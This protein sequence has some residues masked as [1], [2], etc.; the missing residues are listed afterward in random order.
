VELEDQSGT[1]SSCIQ[2]RGIFVNYGQGTRMNYLGTEVVNNSNGLPLKSY[3]SKR[4]GNQSLEEAMSGIQ[5]D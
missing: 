5:V 1:W 2:G 3:Q 4:H